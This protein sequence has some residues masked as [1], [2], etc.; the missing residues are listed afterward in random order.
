[1]SDKFSHELT[2]K[3]CFNAQIFLKR[4]IFQ[5]GPANAAYAFQNVH[6][7][8]LNVSNSICSNVMT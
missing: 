2:H 6:L 4:F 7:K 8:I 5:V 3:C 1:M